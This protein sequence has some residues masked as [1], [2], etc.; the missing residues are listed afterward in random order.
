[1]AVTIR[2]KRRAAGGASG[3]P[4]TL[5]T[6]E[7]AYNETDDI[8]Y[9]GFGDDGSGIATTIKAFAGVGAFLQLI[10][11]QTVAGTKT[12][13]SSPIVPT[14]S[15]ADDSAK[16]ATTAFVKAALASL[17][18]A[19]WGSLGGILTD[20]TDLINYISSQVN[21]VI[22]SAPG[23]LDTLNELAA[24]LGDDANF[25]ATITAALAGKADLLLSNL[26]DYSTVRTNLGLGTIAVQNANNV[27]ITGG[28][29]DGVSLDGGTF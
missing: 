18:S 20:Q 16:V 21:A 9:I 7:I 10:G 5:K 14:P 24:A 2:V 12:F 25:A 23:A 11:D 17:G 19:A 28:Y 13:S 3:A 29:I 22:D 4:A 1:M 6:A 27:A 26:S 15:A 8:M